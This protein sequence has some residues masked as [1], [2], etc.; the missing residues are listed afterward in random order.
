VVVNDHGV[1][2]GFGDICSG[3]KVNLET[4]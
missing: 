4:R 1:C 2:Y 3:V